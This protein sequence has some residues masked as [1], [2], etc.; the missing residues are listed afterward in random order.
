VL[1]VSHFKPVLMRIK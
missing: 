1:N